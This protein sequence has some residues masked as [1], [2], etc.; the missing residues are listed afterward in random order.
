MGKQAGRA[1]YRK[2]YEE[3]HPVVRNRIDAQKE[4]LRNGTATA[5]ETAGTPGAHSEV[6]AM[7]KV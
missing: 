1:A 2:F 3:A 5:K 6:V 7:D 4:A